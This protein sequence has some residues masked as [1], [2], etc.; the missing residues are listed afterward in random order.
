M[1]LGE[2]G[3]TRGY[4]VPYC[5]RCGNELLMPYLNEEGDAQ[6]A[7]LQCPPCGGR[8]LYI[9]VSPRRREWLL[10]LLEAVAKYAGGESDGRASQ[11]G[12]K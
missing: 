11:E 1:E 4:P 9:Y 6:Y 12:D 5:P 3:V 10:M 7:I 2:P 8:G